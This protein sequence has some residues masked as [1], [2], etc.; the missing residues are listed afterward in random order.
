MTDDDLAAV[1]R[2]ALEPD[3]AAVLRTAAKQGVLAY[4]VVFGAYGFWLPNDPR[5]SWSDFVASW[6]LFRAGGP[7]G[8]TECPPTG[9]HF[10]G[11][12][13]HPLPPN[14]NSVINNGLRQTDGLR[15]AGEVGGVAGR[16]GSRRCAA[17][18]GAAQGVAGKLFS[19]T[20][21]DRPCWQAGRGVSASP[22]LSKSQCPWHPGT[23]IPTHPHPARLSYCITQA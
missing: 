12:G 21:S 23:L 4:H 7:V 14:Y 5:G 9:A 16:S 20:D 15:Q 22:P 18:Y 10:G 11:G 19:A 8:R 13:R 6:E 3:N 1:D 17:W 2:T